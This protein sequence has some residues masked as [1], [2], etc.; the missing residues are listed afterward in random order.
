MED[1]TAYMRRKMILLCLISPPLSV[2]LGT[3]FGEVGEEEVVAGGRT[4]E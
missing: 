4:K 3:L 2:H 1:V